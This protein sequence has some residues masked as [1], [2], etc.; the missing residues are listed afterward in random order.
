MHFRIGLGARSAQRSLAAQ[1]HLFGKRW[2]AMVGPWI[3]APMST[4]HDVLLEF[5]TLVA[6]IVTGA[7]AVGAAVIGARALRSKLPLNNRSQ[8]RPPSSVMPPYW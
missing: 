5:Q 2:S 1:Q 7:L 3:G 4:F 6:G 8:G